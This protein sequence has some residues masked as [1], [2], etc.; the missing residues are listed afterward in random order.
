MKK[1]RLPQWVSW[2]RLSFAVFAFFSA[3]IVLLLHLA[4][5]APQLSQTEKSTLIG[6][7]HWNAIVNDP[8]HAPLKLLQWLTRFAPQSH[9]IFIDRLP[10]VA[11]ALLSLVLFIYILRNW[12]GPRSTIFGFSLLV[13]SAWFL[14]IGRFAGTDIE[15]L[16]GVLS[17]L[18]VHIGLN[19]QEN[20]RSISY[21]WLVTN[22]VLLFI[23]GF[24]WF[25]ILNALWQR[26]ELVI[27]W[28]SLKPVWNRICWL[29]LAVIGLAALIISFIRTPHLILT[30]MGAPTH[31]ASWQLLLKQL[32]NTVL[33][34]VY[35]GPH[36]PQLWL[37]R[38]PLL[39]AFLSIMLAAGIVFYIQ[40]WQ[41]ER[42][43]ILFSYLLLGIILISL[44]GDVRL[45]V[46]VPIIYLVIVAGIAYV[47][48]FWLS[49]FPSNPVARRAGISIVAFV[50]A[51]SCFYNLQQYFIAWPHN[52]ETVHVY[53]HVSP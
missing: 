46:I 42:T 19:D 17:L 9:V 21:I 1:Y 3:S 15:Y 37:G 26:T 47:L 18:A 48:R 2:Q 52:P 51:L 32:A 11:L 49:V 43:R 24:V 16:A 53:R 35:R 44:G 10:S 7:Q 12:Y 38:L 4:S 36:N 45:S 23:P 40:H 27:L 5:L 14:H 13:A 50:V 6:S 39:D 22:L 8:L 41:A 33:A 20:R 34:F 28:Q 30:W 29:F 25:V 31:F